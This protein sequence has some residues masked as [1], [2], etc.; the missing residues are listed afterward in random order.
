MYLIMYIYFTYPR[1]RTKIQKK[2]LKDFKRY[3]KY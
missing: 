3:L 1:K 2:L